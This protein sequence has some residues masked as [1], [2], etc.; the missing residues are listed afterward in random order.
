MKITDARYTDGRIVTANLSGDIAIK[1][2]LDAQPVLSGTI[3]LA[4]TVIT[5][6]ERLPGSA[7]RARRQAQERAGR[8][9]R[10]R[11]RR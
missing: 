7:A 1:G 11:K 9:A 3:N 4:K 6:P 2:P 5:I 10:G 8:G